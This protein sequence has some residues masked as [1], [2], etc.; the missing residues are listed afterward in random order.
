[1]GK[2]GNH[3]CFYS[4]AEVLAEVPKAIDFRDLQEFG[5]IMVHEQNTVNTIVQACMC[6]YQNARLHCIGLKS[7]VRKVNFYQ[8]ASSCGLSV[9]KRYEFVNYYEF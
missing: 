8:D 9:L 7:R 2:T 4:A 3:F 6:T 5:K 1:M